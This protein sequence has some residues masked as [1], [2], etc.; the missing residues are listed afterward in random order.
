MNPCP[1][2]WY[3]AK[4]FAAGSGQDDLTG[5][6]LALS[7]GMLSPLPHSMLRHHARSFAHG[8]TPVRREIVGPDARQQ[9]EYH[10]MQADH[11]VILILSALLLLGGVLTSCY[12]A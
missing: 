8:S 5:V 2:T 10:I 9:E 6:R 12:V 11:R 7:R 4:S 3:S 1:R